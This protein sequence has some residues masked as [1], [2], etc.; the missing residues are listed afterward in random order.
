MKKIILVLCLTMLLT[1]CKTGQMGTILSGSGYV[2]GALLA[3]GYKYFKNGQVTSADTND[4]ATTAN[5]LAIFGNIA[6]QA[7][8]HYYFKKELKKLKR[9]R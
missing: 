2:G 5:T 3:T 1:G 4:I 8:D 7:T 6:G 9:K